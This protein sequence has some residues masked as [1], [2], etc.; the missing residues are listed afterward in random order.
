MASSPPQRQHRAQ[1]LTDQDVRS[2]AALSDR[3][4]FRA[5]L[6][7]ILVPRVVGTT[8]HKLVGDF[9][10]ELVSVFLSFWDMD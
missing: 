6:D 10:G 2:L 4:R 7:P 3:D 5:V 9:I 1:E 8:N